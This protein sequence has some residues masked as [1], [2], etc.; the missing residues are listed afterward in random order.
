MH[1]ITPVFG[2]SSKNKSAT[3]SR[4]YDG[5]FYNTK[6]LS[7]KQREKLRKRKAFNPAMSEF[8]E[9]HREEFQFADGVSRKKKPEGSKKPKKRRE[10]WIHRTVFERDY[11]QERKI[12]ESISMRKKYRKQPVQKDNG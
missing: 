9:E 1:V 2:G 4:R 5:I 10:I 8:R 7:R 12:M 11:A 6:Y 3:R